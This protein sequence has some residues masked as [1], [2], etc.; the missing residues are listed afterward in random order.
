MLNGHHNEAQSTFSVL[1]WI[2]KNRIKNGK[3]LLN[4]RITVNGQRAELSA[5]REVSVLEWDSKA[6]SLTGRGHEAKEINNHLAM[7]K[8]KLLNCQSKLE[9]R[10]IV[11]TAKAL[12]FEIQQSG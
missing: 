10:N 2:A 12:K 3:A 4:I 6:Q 9:A 5:Q 7:I 8:S 11:V 1:F